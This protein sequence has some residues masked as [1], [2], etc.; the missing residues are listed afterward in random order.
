MIGH[1]YNLL[2]LH[3]NMDKY[4]NNKNNIKIGDIYGRK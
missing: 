4:I 2:Q 1:C 3:V